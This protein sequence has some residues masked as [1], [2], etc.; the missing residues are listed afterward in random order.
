V[1]KYKEYECEAA[2]LTEE[3]ANNKAGRRRMRIERMMREGGG[4][5]GGEI[6]DMLQKPWARPTFESSTVINARSWAARYLAI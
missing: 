2:E 6:L 3:W 5:G 4:G 1:R